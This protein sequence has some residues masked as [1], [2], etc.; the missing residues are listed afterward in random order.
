MDMTV[1]AFF[2][3][4]CLGE[5]T[6]PCKSRAKHTIPLRKCDVRLWHQGWLLDHES[7]LAHLLQVDSATIVIANTKNG[8]K[9][10]V[11]YHDAIEG[12]CCLVA[13][14]AWQIAIL[15]GMQPTTP[16]STVCLP[17][18]NISCIT[19]RDMFIAVRWEAT[20]DQLLSHRH[21]LDQVSS[22][23]LLAGRAMAMK[24]SGAT[25]SM[26]MRIG[27]WTSLMYLTYIRL[28]IGA[29]SA[30]MAWKMSTAFTFQ[31]VC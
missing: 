15:Q 6:S 28:Q 27:C 30:G 1:I 26:I 25:D 2:F 29:L 12:S 18:T 16:L 10:A 14:L 19:G 20:F 21:T 8:M 22:H 31:N 24:L 4:L 7:T 11:V 17:H 23:S 13:A 3:L 5:Y 9:G